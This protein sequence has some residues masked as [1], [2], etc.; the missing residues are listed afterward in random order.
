M[1]KNKTTELIASVALLAVISC[2]V[3]LATTFTDSVF[4]SNYP[5]KALP[6]YLMGINFSS[7]GLSMVIMWAVGKAPTWKGFTVLCTFLGIAALLSRFMPDMQFSEYEEALRL[8][9]VHTFALM[10]N[11]ATWN[12]AANQ[13]HSSHA[14]TWLPAMASGLTV[15]GLIGGIITVL[16]SGFINIFTLHQLSSALLCIAIPFPFL[17]GR[18]MGKAL[19]SS[20]STNFGKSFSGTTKTSTVHKE[21][22]ISMSKDPLVRFLA[23]V[24]LLFAIA[25]TLADY[26][27][28]ATLQNQGAPEKVALFLGLL[29]TTLNILVLLG[30]WGFVSKLLNRT[31]LKGLFSLYPWPI[32][33]S[34]GLSFILPNLYGAFIVRL[35]ERSLRP[36]IFY[37]ATDTLVAPMR[38][39][40]KSK[41]I[42]LNKGIM[43]Q[44]GTL[45]AM[46]LVMFL[47]EYAPELMASSALIYGLMSLVLIISLFAG[48]SLNRIY[49]HHLRQSLGLDIADHEADTPNHGDSLETM[50]S[51]KSVVFDPSKL[52]LG[53]SALTGKQAE[54]ILA[55]NPLEMLLS[56]MSTH[57]KADLAS[58]ALLLQELKIQKD[59][60]IVL[61]ILRILRASR[62]QNLKIP[63]YLLQHEWLEI[64]MLARYL[65]APNPLQ[66]SIE[67]HK[68]LSKFS[69]QTFSPYKYAGYFAG[70]SEILSSADTT[71]WWETFLKVSGAQQ[72]EIFQALAESF[73]R[74]TPLEPWT[75]T[76]G[77][78]L[79]YKEL[80]P[81]IDHLKRHPVGRVIVN[82]IS[83]RNLDEEFWSN[84]LDTN[85]GKSKLL[86]C[87]LALAINS[88]RQRSLFFYEWS[89]RVSYTDIYILSGFLES[90]CPILRRK[91]ISLLSL[92]IL[93]FDNS[94]LPKKPIIRGLQ[95][96]IRETLLVAGSMGE[97]FSY[98]SNNSLIG[99]RFTNAQKNEIYQHLNR[100]YE[101]Q[102]ELFFAFSALLFGAQ[103]TKQAYGRF[104]QGTDFTRANVVEFFRAGELQSV[105]SPMLN[106]LNISLPKDMV[107]FVGKELGLPPETPIIGRL[108]QRDGFEWLRFLVNS[109][110]L[111]SPIKDK[112]ERF[113]QDNNVFSH[114][115]P[116]DYVEI[117]KKLSAIGP[118]I[119]AADEHHILRRSLSLPL[120]SLSALQARYRENA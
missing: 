27:Y 45:L 44:T 73:F 30:Q 29:N 52:G 46:G 94:N 105:V 72:K 84:C 49:Q 97:I 8:V 77:M 23:T 101:H 96:T 14:R 81:C 92:T 86:L 56:L 1:A 18:V 110:V 58:I 19:P 66:V 24:T 37:S 5:V 83:K 100:T 55:S 6:Y 60:N 99:L 88:R 22:N 36:L 17:L 61:A 67:T 48:R 70:A 104:K 39:A 112:V 114:I 15:G 82:L 87:I 75:V 16:S 38:G 80:K 26:Q 34:I 21:H 10:V 71:T 28:K 7:L 2:V 63:H 35:L 90:S 91:A 115:A 57:K 102:V 3:S 68:E 85:H 108:I 79:R 107:P 95:K 116:Q 78:G 113:H 50:A 40:L 32:L 54:K 69:L 103:T 117:V 111:G 20:E 33:G 109:S 31:S 74:G 53:D 106:L 59:P 9:L 51:D 12:F 11:V 65:C 4:L 76:N 62:G 98:D 118:D 43:T 41:V 89:Q 13:V 120:S 42:W 93:K 64:T 119:D 47:F 25:G